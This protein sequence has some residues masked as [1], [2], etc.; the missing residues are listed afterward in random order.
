MA[1]HRLFIPA[2]AFLPN[3]GN[4]NVYPKPSSIDDSNDAAPREI[5][6]FKDSGTRISAYATFQVPQNYVGTPKMVTHW[7]TT[8]TSGNVVNEVATK[9]IAD[10]ES[11]DPASLNDD[12]VSATV[13]VPGTARVRKDTSHTLTGTYAAGDLVLLEVARDGAQNSGNDDTLAAEWLFEGASF[14]YVDQ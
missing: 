8:A 11:M 9:A 7:R 1:T 4:S 6:A 12:A 2:A 13:A 3:L 10:G 5:L 14:E